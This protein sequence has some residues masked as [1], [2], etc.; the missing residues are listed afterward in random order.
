MLNTLIIDDEEDSRITLHNFLTRYCPD[1]RIAG[2]ADSVPAACELIAGSMP[3]LVFLDISM[4]HEDGFALFRR[5]PEPAFHTIIVTAYDSFALNAIKHQALDY[6]LKPVNIGEL[7]QAV[8]RVKVIREQGNVQR[9]I[10]QLLQSSRKP[11]LPEKIGLP[12]ADGFLYIPVKDI[13][14]CEAEGSYTVFYIAGRSKVMVSRILGSYEAL[15]KE[16]GFIRVHREHLINPAHVERYQRGRGGTV[17]MSDKKEV[18][19]SQRKKDDFL[20]QINGFSDPDGA[21]A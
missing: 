15:L 20:K 6:I 4:P 3:D 11:D 7:V 2:E 14:R 1:V 8:N 13:I 19:V 18:I 16:Y 17:F 10:S 12:Q 9:Q 21:G 5:F